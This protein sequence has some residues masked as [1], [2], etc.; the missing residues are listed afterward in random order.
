MIWYLCYVLHLFI[1]KS[2]ASHSRVSCLISKTYPYSK[3]SNWRRSPSVPNQRCKQSSPK[4]SSPILQCSYL[5]PIANPTTSQVHFMS[6]NHKPLTSIFS[7][8]S[9]K[10]ALLDI[11][12][13]HILS[14]CDTLYR[15]MISP[16]D[17]S[18]TFRTLCFFHGHTAFA[19]G[20][21]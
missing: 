11:Q 17:S 1:T 5:V 12:S 4:R 20:K 7:V 16:S 2:F 14:P 19:D 18:S 10:V 15:N 8:V 3:S 21:L 13:F 6:L 9:A